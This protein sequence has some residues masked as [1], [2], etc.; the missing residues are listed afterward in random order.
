MTR[1]REEVVSSITILIL[2]FFVFSVAGW[3]W[4]VGLHLVQDG[5]FVKRGVLSGPWLPIY[6]T[7][8]V[9]IML[10]LQR[11]FRKPLRLFFMIMAMCG[12]MEYVTG[13]FLETYFHTKWWDYSDLTFQIQGRV[14]LVG[15][16][17]FGM[18]GMAFVYLLRPCLERFLKGISLHWREILCM[19]LV[20]IFLVDLI[21]SF[22]NP[23]Q[24]AGITTPVMITKTLP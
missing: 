1:R 10:V 4:E 7:G 23:N 5:V 21:W 2:L 9:L 11:F 8:G 19:V 22:Q 18:G 6:G 3:L 14:C 12:L 16:L 13:W 24:G 15:L 17:L 20:G